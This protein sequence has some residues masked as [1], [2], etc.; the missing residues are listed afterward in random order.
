[1]EAETDP[2]RK[3]QLDIIYHHAKFLEAM[4]K[5]FLVLA[6]LEHGEFRVRKELIKDLY[7]E[8]ILPAMVGLKERYPDS[9]E[10]YDVSMGGVGAIEV[11]GDRGLLEIVYRNLFGNALKYRY[12]HG[13]VSYGVVVQPHQYIFNVWNEG[14]GVA[15]DQR[16]RIFDKFY[17]VDEE[18]VRQKRGTGLG[19]YN[20]RR[21]IEAHGGRIWC[22]SGH[23]SWVNF[24]FA[25]PRE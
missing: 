14:P 23:G 11:M 3:E 9:F 6:E 24:L 21:I 5:D 8:V 20:I 22:E 15:P 10:S 1:L 2:A 19:L 17:R 4:S 13:K 16:E 18:N 7:I 12:P 25:L